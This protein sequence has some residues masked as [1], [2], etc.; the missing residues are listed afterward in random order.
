MPH[1]Y[2]TMHPLQFVTQE[3]GVP[4]NDEHS[5]DCVALIEPAIG[6]GMHPC[7]TLAITR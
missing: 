7:V 5:A 2:H 3:G 6:E 1:E 4:K